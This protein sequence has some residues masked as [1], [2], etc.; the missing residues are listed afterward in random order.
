MSL[1]EQYTTQLAL[2]DRAVGPL[3]IGIC[4]VIVLIGAVYVGMRRVGREPPLPRGRRPR[5]GAWQTRHE[6]FDGPSD[7]GP[8]HQGEAARSHDSREVEPDV[9]PTD[10]RRRF[11]HEVH[12][13][14]VHAGRARTHGRRH[15]GPNVD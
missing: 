10:G 9:M 13:A 8:G 15:S 1:S 6:E 12:D 2:P 11:P 3:I 5:A 14:G 4:I 7:H